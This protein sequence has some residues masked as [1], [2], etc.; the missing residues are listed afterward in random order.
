MPAPLGSDR[1][2]AASFG[3]AFVASTFLTWAVGCGLALLLVPRELERG[4]LPTEVLLVLWGVPVAGVTLVAQTLLLLIGR[5]LRL[6]RRRAPGI[7]SCLLTS[8]VTLLGLWA[9]L[10]VLGGPE[11]VIPRL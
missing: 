9:L 1:S 2:S 7:P 8:A 3:L 4:V 10:L 6:G 11:A 5:K